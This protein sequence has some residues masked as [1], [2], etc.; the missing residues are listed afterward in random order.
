MT[1]ATAIIVGASSLLS[2]EIA[3]QLAAQGVELALLAQDPDSLQEFADS[4]PTKVHLF[5]LQIVEPQAIISSL[6]GVWQQLGGAH[7]VLVNTGL[8]SYDP[9][10][11]W[12]PEQDIIT[13]NVQGFAAVC[14]T[15]FRLFREQG[16]GQLAAVNSIAGLR[17][18]PSVAYH[19]SKA[20]AT[21]YLEGLSMHAQRLKLPITITDIQLGLLDKAAM[22][23][24]RLWLSPPNEVARQIIKA[25]QG[26]KRRVYVTKRWRLV[27]WLT[28]LLPEFVYNTRHWRTKAERL[29][30]K[31]EGKK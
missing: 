3:K 14:N 17:G 12:G 19:A 25:M 16:Y 18:G 23:Q 21:N 24:S 30:A 28:K 29:A 27:A 8:N 13:V 22:Q 11:P 5:P 1:Q 4:L 15:A 2:R 6:E 26:G 10:L 7:L 9:Q 20:F 31:A